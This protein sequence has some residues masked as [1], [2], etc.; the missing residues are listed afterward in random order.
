MSFPAKAYAIFAVT[1]RSENCSDTGG[2]TGSI[3]AGPSSPP[4]TNQFVAATPP[5]GGRLPLVIGRATLCRGES[6]RT[7]PKCH[8]QD[9]EGLLHGSEQETAGRL[10]VNARM[11]SR[12]LVMSR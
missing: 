5:S 2:L 1:A 8:L 4:G 12:S 9:L 10:D 6:G 3:N 7:A 11:P